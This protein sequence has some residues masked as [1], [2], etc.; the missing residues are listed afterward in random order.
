MN[1]KKFKAVGG[2]LAATSAAS[3]AFAPSLS[4]AVLTGLTASY[5]I[6]GLND[7]KQTQH[8][9]RRN[10]PVLGN[11]RYILEVLRP[12]I[13]QYFIESDHEAAPFSRERRAVVY[14]RA[15]GM[16]DE[17]AFGTRRSVYDEGHEWAVHS[18]YPKEVELE[19]C[20][21]MIGATNPACTQP[22]SAALLNVSAMSYGALSANAVLALNT[23]ACKGGFYHN[24]GEGGISRYH[25]QPGGDIC[26]NVGTGY[27]GCGSGSSARTFEPSLFAENASLPQV[28]LIE[29]K[30][31]Q[32]AKPGHGGMLPAAKITPAIA[33][34]RNLGEPP[35][36]DC[37]SPPAHSA[38]SDADGLIAFLQELQS[39][40][41]G[42]PVG[43]KM[44][45]G[46][47]R[48]LID[49]VRAM[50]AADYVPD[51]ITIDGGE[52]GTGA[53]PHEFLNSV[54][55]P[56]EEG[57]YLL[58]SV[59]RAAGLRDRTKIIAA[60]KITSGFSLVKT[61]ALGAD[62]CNAA[63]GFMFSLGCIQALKC[64]NNHCPTGITTQD[65]YLMRGLV[66]PEKAERAQTFQRKTVH[67]AADIVGAMGLDDP[68]QV[69]GTHIMRR[70]P[71]GRVL[72]LREMFP[73]LPDGCFLDSTTGKMEYAQVLGAID[74]NADG[75]VT[76]REFRKFGATWNKA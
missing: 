60:A 19:R 15:K 55:M 34:A 64:H 44:C 41:G 30:L 68:S 12:E 3:L 50:S 6:V 69:N 61:L 54:G 35:Y 24:T 33:E 56:F 22:Y 62:V 31:S 32:G 49:I 17:V 13:R 23:A 40:S 46:K 39:L 21:T 45:I 76:V 59:L 57:I 66:V 20:R 10:F 2:V 11:V 67:M 1:A 65:P 53:A 63:R 74:A 9:I 51:F 25:K 5:W 71:D 18:L 70:G 7:M 43:F 16:K 38:F 14:A 73:P 26:W 75:R 48:E 72:T 58:D 52:G 4:A 42:K 29:L 8:A 47:P 27:F 28:K 37:N 36:K